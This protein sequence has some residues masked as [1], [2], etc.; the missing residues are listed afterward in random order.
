MAPYVGRDCGLEIKYIK[1]PENYAADTLSGL[2]LINSDVTESDIK[3]EQLAE[4]YGVDQLDCDT[5]PLIYR[6]INKY[7]REDKNLVEEV[8]RANYIPYRQTDT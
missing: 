2:P 3:R 7:Q 1:G 8:K 6:T 5:F 4:I